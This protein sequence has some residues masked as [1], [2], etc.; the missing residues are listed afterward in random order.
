MNP[1]VPLL[2]TLL[3]ALFAAFV[4]WRLVRSFRRGLSIRMQVFVAMA[5]VSGGFAALLGLVAVERLETRVARLLAEVSVQEAALLAAVVPFSGFADPAARGAIHGLGHDARAARPWSPT[6]I[7]NS[8]G[9]SVELVDPQGKV[10]FSSGPRVATG[11]L[12]QA[13]VRSPQGQ[14][15]GAVRVSRESLGFRSF[16]GE[17]ATRAAWLTLL[18][19]VCVACAAALIGRAIAAPI[20]RITQ[21][22]SRIAQGERQAVLPAPFGREV[23]TLTRA[24]ESMRKELEGRHLAEKLAADLSHELKNPVAAIRAAAEVLSDGALDEPDRETARR[25]VARIIEASQRLQ[26]ILNNLLMLTRLQARGVLREP[27]DLADLVRQSIEA[28]TAQ[29]TRKR[30]ELRASLPTEMLVLGDE[31]WLRRAVDN[32]IDNAIAFAQ[33]DPAG[34]AAPQVFLRLTPAVEADHGL[35]GDNSQVT[36]EIENTGPGIAPKVL[37]RLFERFVTTRRDTGGSGLGLAIVAA[38][39]EQHGGRIAVKQP[40]PPSTC[41]CLTLPAA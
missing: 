29:A 13:L 30:V 15:I 7:P 41:F 37:H 3:L 26:G 16:L 9:L 12:E 2:A 32:L 27:V 33:A 4:G 14:V 8:V 22:A 36:L 25:F 5:T 19:V 10:L 6:A 39:A 31:P 24:V 1:V 35:T 23:R 18:L 11:L 38:V 17:V 20:E 21:A 34:T 40:G 28:H